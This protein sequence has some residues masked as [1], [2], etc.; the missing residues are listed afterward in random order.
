[1][2]MIND[3][4]HVMHL[5]LW[6]HPQNA[7]NDLRNLRSS[8]S[9]IILLNTQVASYI[10]RFFAFC[11]MRAPRNYAF[12]ANCGIAHFAGAGKCPSWLPYYA[13]QQERITQKF[14]PVHYHVWELHALPPPSPSRVRY[15][16]LTAD[17]NDIVQAT[18]I[19]NIIVM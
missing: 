13:L 3:T 4:Y 6:K 9:A 12:S 2:M 5:L 10:A 18:S 11:R 19:A 17:N 16:L 14:R 8:H 15:A 7:E 1:M